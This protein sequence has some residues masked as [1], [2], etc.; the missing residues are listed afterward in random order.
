MSLTP[1][2]ALLL[3]QD[4]A[5][6]R[7]LLAHIEERCRAELL[8]NPLDLFARRLLMLIE[9]RNTHGRAQYEPLPPP[10]AEQV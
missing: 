4:N 2:I 9:E 8:L 3:Q 1:T 7:D 10:G 5:E 6:L